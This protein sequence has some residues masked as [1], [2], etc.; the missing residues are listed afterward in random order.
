MASSI[1]EIWEE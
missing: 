1:G